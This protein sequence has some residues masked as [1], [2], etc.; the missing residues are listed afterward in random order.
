MGRFPSPMAR[1]DSAY[2]YPKMG[3][4]IDYSSPSPLLASSL[5]SQVSGFDLMGSD[6]GRQHDVGE[7]RGAAG[8]H[9]TEEG[10][11]MTGLN[12][13]RITKIGG[14]GGAPRVQRNIVPVNNM[15]QLG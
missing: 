15:V 1:I 2:H 5:D 12:F 4:Y 6:A 7:G 11:G 13:A 14:V 8:Q 10:R 3:D 9:G